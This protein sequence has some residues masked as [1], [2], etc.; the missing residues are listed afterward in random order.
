MLGLFGRKSDHP[1]ADPKSA[2][3]LLEELPKNDT[4]KTLQEITEWVESVRADDSFRLDGRFTALRLLDETARAHERKLTR[5]LYSSSA[6]SRFQE[7]RLGTA[8]EDYYTQLS[9]AY[10]E[11]LDGCREGGKGVAVL[12][13]QQ[14]LITARTIHAAMGRMKCAATRYAQPD[15]AV[16]PLLASCYVHAE[17]EQYLKDPLE[18]YP[19]LGASASVCGEFAS[20]LLWWLSGTGTLRPQQAHLAQRL[21]A[22]LSR[23]YTVDAQPTASPVLAFDVA[24]PRPPQRYTGDA[25]AASSLRFVGLGEVQG[26]LDSLAKTLDKG[27]VPND[28]NLGGSFEAGAVLAVVQHLTAQWA[29]PPPMRRAPRRNIHVNLQV[30]DGFSGLLDQTNVGLDFSSGATGSWEVEEI[31]ANGFR[32]ILPAVQ[33]DS[34]HIGLLLGIRPEK[35]EHWGAGIVRRLSRDGS[36]NLHVGVEMLSTRLEGAVLSEGGRTGLDGEPALW[37]MRNNDAGE[38]WLLMKPDTF[39]VSRTLQMQAG[40]KRYL[41]MPLALVEKGEDFDLARFR[42]IEQE[43][44]DEETY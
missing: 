14:P 38:A 12:K 33:A 42:K 27:M 10:G 31:S 17:T 6:L 2:Q 29:S 22:H 25:V 19:G 13:P 20:A 28:L 7:N 34:V 23:H 41:L 43:S 18:L 9:L 30:A 16:W 40:A 32:C 36:N 44:S 26:Q 39:A 35:V 4:L 15:P 3:Q 24:Q 1:L 21:T 37:L 8:L 5:D 11:V